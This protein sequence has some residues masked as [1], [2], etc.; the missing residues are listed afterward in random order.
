MKKKELPNS[1]EKQKLTKQIQDFWTRHV[2]SE[3]IFGKDITSHPR[4]EEQYFLDLEAQRYRSHR[5]LLPWI[6]SM[7]KGRS[8]LEIGCGVGLDTFTMTKHGLNITAVD[9]TYVAIQT[10]IKR[11]RRHKLMA[12][13]TVAD[14]CHLPFTDNSFDYVYSFGV[15]HHVADTEQSLREVFRVLKPGG[16]AKIMLYNRRSLNE[17]VHRLTKIPF[18]DKSEFCPV[19]RRFSIPEVKALFGSFNNCKIALDFIYGEG[20][21]KLFHLT[22][23]WLYRILSR[24]WGWHIM[25]SVQK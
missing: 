11:F 24:Y 8:V 20:Y 22:P 3:R 12:L 9:L 2:N 14:A 17:I 1:K 4:G 13:F 7:E 23:Y 25:I 5:H 19:V 10:A 16:E 18:E 6:T 15:L 21:G